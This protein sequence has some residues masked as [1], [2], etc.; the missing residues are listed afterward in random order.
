MMVALV[1]RL[2]SYSLVRGYTDVDALQGSLE[3]AS[4][5]TTRLSRSFLLSLSSILGWNLWTSDIATAF[6]QGLPQERKLWVKLPAECVQLLGASDD[7]R[8]L[9]VKPVYGQLDAPRRWYLE[10][11]RRLKSLGLRQHLLDPCAF[12]IYDADH[13]LS[14]DGPAPPVDASTLGEAGLCGMICLVTP[15]PLCISG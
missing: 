8:M 4:P 12:L 11:V 7:C 1:Q 3:T 15:H 9:L 6:L 10:A 2:D 13:R 5:T 14:E